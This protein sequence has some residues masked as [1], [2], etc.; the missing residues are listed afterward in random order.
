MNQDVG[1]DIT[2]HDVIEV[3]QPYGKRRGQKQ[4]AAYLK[5]G[6]RHQRRESAQHV[7]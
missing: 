4:M 3:G 7:P 1:F 6:E 5:K 2:E